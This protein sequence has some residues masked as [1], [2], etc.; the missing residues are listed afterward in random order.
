MSWFLLDAVEGSPAWAPAVEVAAG[1]ERVRRAYAAAWRSTRLAGGDLADAL[2]DAVLYGE[3]AWAQLAA[4]GP[5]AFAN[6]VIPAL[7]T[8]VARV[9][10]VVAA[11][12]AQAVAPAWPAQAPVDEDPARAAVA[13]GL[14]AGDAGAVVEALIAH[15]RWRGAGPLARHAA[16]AWDGTAWRAAQ[17]PSA[18]PLVGVDDVLARLHANVGAFV[19]GRPAHATL[20]YGPRGS[21]KSTAVRGLLARFSAQGLRLAEVGSDLAALP[22]AL[23]AL[24][25]WPY[26]TLL[27]LDDLAFEEGERGDRP[28]RSLLEGGLRGLPPRSLVVATSNRRHLV[29]ERFRDRPDPLDD[30]VHAW[31]THHERLA[32]ADRFGLVLTFP[33]VDRARYLTL[34]TEIAAAE[35]CELDEDWERHAIAFAER[36]NGYAGRTARQYV[37]ELV[38]RAGAAAPTAP[39]AA[40]AE[41]E[42]APTAPPA[43]DAAP[44]DAG[45]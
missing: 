33:H 34:V 7:R 23:A 39:A 37:T 20:L 11:A 4:R 44:A 28:L 13:A 6:D 15:A 3:S 40:D 36:G 38:Q 12:T 10:Q 21:G 2:A 19:A 24:G 26:P 27:V 30:D 1:G 17:P 35:G 8:D 42:A 31:D 43:A 9:A 16:V 32:L 29:R 45:G 41:P 5:A 18:D 22:R 14:R 25:P